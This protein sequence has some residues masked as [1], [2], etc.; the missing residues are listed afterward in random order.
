MNICNFDNSSKGLDNSW[1]F[2]SPSCFNM[3]LD[4]SDAFLLKI[5][6]GQLETALSFFLNSE[7]LVE[8]NFESY[9]A[10]LKRL[11]DILPLLHDKVVLRKNSHILAVNLHKAEYE[12]NMNEELVSIEIDNFPHSNFYYLDDSYKQ[13]DIRAEIIT[14]LTYNI[15]KT[16]YLNSNDKEN[17]T[18]IEKDTKEMLKNSRVYI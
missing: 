11:H 18:I 5:R 16:Y 14:L 9:D 6:N 12:I 13:A 15:L 1:R 10:E 17:F 8:E 7:N 4:I 2:V 3:A